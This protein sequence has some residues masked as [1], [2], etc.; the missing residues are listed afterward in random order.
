MPPKHAGQNR[1]RPRHSHPHF[2]QA[3]S[4]VLTGADRRSFRRAGTRMIHGYRSLTG[5]LPVIMALLGLMVVVVDQLQ[6][7][8]G[9]TP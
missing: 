9:Q 2:E 6:I 7:P 3:T 4:G 5:H 1:L 8:V